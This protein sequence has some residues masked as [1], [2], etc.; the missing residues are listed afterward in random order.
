MQ[1]FLDIST[2]DT[3]FTKYNLTE[4]EL[5]K[6]AAVCQREQGTAV[7]AAAEASLIANRFEM[8]GGSYGTIYNYVRNSAWFGYS[9]SYMDSATV[10]SD[11]VE[12]V[13]S[14]LVDGKRTLPFFID[15]HDWIY[16]IS[17]AETN[18]QSIP[19][20]AKEQF[21]PN[22]TV[23]QNVYGSTWTFYCFPAANSDPFGYIWTDLA[24]PENDYYYDYYSGELVHGSDVGAMAYANNTGRVI[25]D[26]DYCIM[27]KGGNYLN[28]EQDVWT[29]KQVGSGFYR[30]MNRN[31]GLFLGVNNDSAYRNIRVELQQGSDFFCNGMEHF[32]G[33]GNRAV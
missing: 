6:I 5:I 19:T 18:G 33:M 27:N 30:I 13:R 20:Y 11:I 25:P 4:E 15:E 31:T 28:G 26:G 21:V 24:T 22:E 17:Y 29:I 14:V 2:N 9:G 3:G 23:L 32:S 7:G 12:A 8:Y 1:E 10:Y 16:D